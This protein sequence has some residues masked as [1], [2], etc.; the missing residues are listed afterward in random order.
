[1]TRIPA[2]SDRMRAGRLPQCKLSW[3]ISTRPVE[4]VSGCAAILA[5]SG[6][7]AW[8]PD[9]ATSCLTMT[10]IFAGASLGDRVVTLIRD[11][12]Q[13]RSLRL[14]RTPDAVLASSQAEVPT[15]TRRELCLVGYTPMVVRG[16]NAALCP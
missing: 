10:E 2:D 8:L 5:G 15:L 6:R 16:L 9:P 12:G 4:G 7:R 1:V 3:Q 13:G 11:A 14:V